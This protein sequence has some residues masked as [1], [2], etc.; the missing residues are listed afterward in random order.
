[1]CAL[2]F[3]VVNTITHSLTIVNPFRE[4]MLKTVKIF[5]PL[6]ESFSDKGLFFYLT[7]CDMLVT[8]AR[9]N[10]TN[11]VAIYTALRLYAI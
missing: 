10:R 9:Y 4:K 3:P 8:L 5:K 1:M 11:A 6:P 2:S 7:F